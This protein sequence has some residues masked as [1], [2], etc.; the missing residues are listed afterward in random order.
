MTYMDDIEAGGSPKFVKAVMEN[1][2]QKEL[3]KLW[4]FSKKKS[5]WMCIANRKRNIENLA[6]EV[7]QGVLDK[8]EVYKLLGNMVNSKGKPLDDAINNS[9]LPALF[10]CELNDNIRDIVS[11]PIRDGGLGI[12]KVN[13]N[14]DVSYETSSQLTLPLTKQIIDQSDTLPDTDLVKEA[15]SKATQHLEDMLKIRKWISQNES[16][17]KEIPNRSSQCEKEEVNQK[18]NTKTNQ[19][20]N[21]SRTGA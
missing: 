10:G 20:R 2:K 3:E 1:C 14:A 4:E 11:L 12:R 7:T 6:V 19:I 15:K 13:E 8:T 17:F 16:G 18:T 9:F 5:K 21:C